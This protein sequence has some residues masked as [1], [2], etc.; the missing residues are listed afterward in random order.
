MAGLKV[1]GQF[2]P[3]GYVDDDHLGLSEFQVSGSLGTRRP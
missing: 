1:L 3:G 2:G